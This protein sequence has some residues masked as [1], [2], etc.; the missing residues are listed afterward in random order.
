MD[1]VLLGLTIGMANA[2]LAVGL[3]LIYMSNR[4]VN[5]AHG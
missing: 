1:L 5:F 3:V 2:L 4:V